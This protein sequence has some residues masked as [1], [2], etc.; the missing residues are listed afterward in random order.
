MKKTVNLKIIGGKLLCLLFA[1][2]V[3]IT[4]AALSSTNAYALDDPKI[5]DCTSALV[6]CV[7]SGTV[8]WSREP[9][10]TVY[11]ARLVKLMTAILALEKFQGNLD[12]ECEVSYSSIEGLSGIAV[13]FEVGEKIPLRHLIEVMIHTGANDAAH[14]IAEAVSGSV[15]EF[16][17]EMNRKAKEL[18][19]DK[20]V[21]TNATG[22]HSADNVTTA[23]D[24]L[25]LAVYCTGNRTL[26]EMCSMI[27]VVIP[28]TNRSGERAYGTTNYLISQRVNQDYYFEAANGMI[29]GSTDEA[30]YCMIASAENGGKNYISVVMGAKD[31]VELVSPESESTDE[32]GNTVIL[33]AVYKTVITGLLDSAELLRW[34]DGNFVF[35]TAVA[36]TMPICQIDVRLGKTT[37][38]VVLVPKSS[39]EAFVPKDFDSGKDFEYSYTLHSQSVT[40]PVKAGTEMGM[41]TVSYKGQLL[42]EVPLVVS[43]NIEQS[44]WLTALDGLKQLAQTPLFKIIIFTFIF[45]AVIYVIVTAARI[46]QIN[47]KKKKRKAQGK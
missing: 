42:G 44:V 28:K 24:M 38:K 1:L 10:K 31:R 11:P 40:A 23:R 20:T 3:I 27:R 18:G 17:A 39:I 8:L 16:V 32:E 15:E 30:G 13:G 6:Y 14:I 47:K 46:A 36:P 21:F 19:M 22:M 25:I 35:H 9:D 33:P 4:S 45:G 34:A 37:D 12:R 26:L 5:S 2:A 29:G 41:L 7:E 43:N